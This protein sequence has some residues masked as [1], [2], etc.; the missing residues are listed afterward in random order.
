LHSASAYGPLD[1]A[2]DYLFKG[3][4]TNTGASEARCNGVQ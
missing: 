2:R 4:V 3:T 1:L